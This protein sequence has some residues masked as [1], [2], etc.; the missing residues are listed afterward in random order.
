MFDIKNKMIFN[1]H[2]EIILQMFI[3]YKKYLVHAMYRQRTEV[4]TVQRKEISSDQ[5]P[6]KSTY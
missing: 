4:N 2:K 1:N 3:N 5:Q 6:D